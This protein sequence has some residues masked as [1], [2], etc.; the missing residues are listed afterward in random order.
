MTRDNVGRYSAST[1]PR[2]L[3]PGGLASEALPSEVK[4][5]GGT[6]RVTA[7]HR[8]DWSLDRPALV[9][10]ITFLCPAAGITPHSG[11]PGAGQDPCPGLGAGR[12]PEPHRDA[13]KPKSNYAPG[14]MYVIPQECIDPSG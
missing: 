9:L 7:S 14:V 1:V 11:V 6:S 12:G 2:A 4:E 13:R 10:E 3:G 8:S 5:R